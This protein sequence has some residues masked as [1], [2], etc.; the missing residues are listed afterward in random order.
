M[1]SGFPSPLRSPV[2]ITGAVSGVGAGG[3]GVAP[4]P[5]VLVPLANAASWASVPLKT[6]WSPGNT[7]ASAY[8]HIVY[9]LHPAGSVP[10]PD[11]MLLGYRAMKSGLAPND[12][13]LPVHRV[14]Q[15]V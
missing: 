9:R 10:A 1:K 11:A 15:S 4:P 5:P 7:P 8:C 6:S 12:E 14:H 3:I 13:V 2:P